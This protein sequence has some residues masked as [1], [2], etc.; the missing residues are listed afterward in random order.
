MMTECAIPI[1]DQKA[2]ARGEA[3][4]RGIFARHAAG[5]LAHIDANSLG[6]A[7]FHKQRKQQASGSRAEIEHL[8]LAPSGAGK[9][10]RRIDERLALR[11]GYQRLG[12]HPKGEAPELAAAEDLSDRLA[13]DA[14]REE[15]LEAPPFLSAQH[16]TGM[17]DESLQR[18]P[19]RAGHEQPR[20][21]PRFAHRR[22]L[23]APCRLSEESA[24]G[25]GLCVL[26]MAD[27]RGVQPRPRQ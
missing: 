13:P 25:P 10:K 15:G 26:F 5:S 3:E 12:R 9:V 17:G 24:G 16:P 1:A 11:T 22:G 4:C 19:G 23:E 2:R 14:S 20:I 18:A 6:G 21:E 7:Q 27:L 8:Q